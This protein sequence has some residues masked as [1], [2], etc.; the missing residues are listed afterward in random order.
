MVA[1][2][3]SY[4]TLL[5]KLLLVDMDHNRIIVQEQVLKYVLVQC[6]C[7]LNKKNS[8]LKLVCVIQFFMRK[9][10]WFSSYYPRNIFNIELFSNYSM[11]C[12]MLSLTHYGEDYTSVTG[13]KA[14]VFE[15]FCMLILT[16]KYS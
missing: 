6:H 2:L 12:L 8:F 9:I 3:V 4:H 14:Q 10:S 1:V 16:I 15:T 5:F 13:G 11:L 7:S